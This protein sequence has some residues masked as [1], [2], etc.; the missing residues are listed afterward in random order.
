MI[1][2]ADGLNAEAAAGVDSILRDASARPEGYWRDAL[3]LPGAKNAA[4]TGTSN[5]CFKRSV[6]GNCTDYGVNNVWTLGYTDDLVV[7]VWVGNA[8]NSPMIREADGLNAAAPVWKAF[9]GAAGKR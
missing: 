4:K 9:M 6:L 8:D 7:G 2:E 5:L 1:P 3:T